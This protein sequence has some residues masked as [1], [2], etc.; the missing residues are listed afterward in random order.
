MA[1]MDKTSGNILQSPQQSLLAGLY[2]LPGTW[3]TTMINSLVETEKKTAKIGGEQNQVAK[4][5]KS[6]KPTSYRATSKS[7]HGGIVHE[8]IPLVLEVKRAI[9]L[10]LRESNWATGK[11]KRRQILV[12]RTAQLKGKSG[13]QWAPDLVVHD[14][15]F[16]DV[17][18]VIFSIDAA[19]SL[20]DVAASFN[21]ALVCF[22]DLAH[23]LCLQVIIVRKVK[24]PE[25]QSARRIISQ[26]EELFTSREKTIKLV[27]WTP[28]DIGTVIRQVLLAIREAYPERRGIRN[29]RD[30]L[31][32][33]SERNPELFSR[34]RIPPRD[35][36]AR[37]AELLKEIKAHDPYL[38]YGKIV[39]QALVR[40][41][42][43]PSQ[44]SYMLGYMSDSTF[45]A[46]LEEYLALQK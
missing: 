14:R 2:I 31:V 29:I 5:A 32:A 22:D 7:H 25:A 12:S 16:H 33:L 9:S 38:S 8:T 15:D 41:A 35:R 10:A 30:T 3:G 20:S 36:E 39:S 19:A 18:A 28:K 46:I 34:M 45:Q 13:L 4:P 37:V 21:R 44:V 27:E 24:G 26:Y 1:K 11:S 23:L 40:K 42:I 43:C 17:H 6:V